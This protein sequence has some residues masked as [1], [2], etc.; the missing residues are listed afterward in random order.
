[1][2]N[3]IEALEKL[4]SQLHQLDIDALSI[5]ELHMQVHNFEVVTCCYKFKTSIGFK[6]DY[7]IS[8]SRGAGDSGAIAIDRGDDRHNR[9]FNSE[10][11][12]EC[13]C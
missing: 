6:Y 4:T 13:N 11:G 10:G 2:K 9:S 3:I 8:S 12:S 5:D 7:S 1:M